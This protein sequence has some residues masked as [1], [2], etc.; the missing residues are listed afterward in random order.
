MSGK[1]VCVE[2][3]VG[4]V[5]GKCMCVEVRSRWVSGKYVC[6]EVRDGCLV[7]PQ[8]LSVLFSEAGSLTEP[9]VQ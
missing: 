7:L 4:W 2:V 5:S 1:F 6:V 8:L 3:G 9:K